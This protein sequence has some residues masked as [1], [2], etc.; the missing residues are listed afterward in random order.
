LAGTVPEAAGDASVK[1]DEAVGG[2]FDAGAAGLAVG[3]ER[4]I[5]S[6]SRRVA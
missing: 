3:Q 6:G 2:G 1:F 5:A 4:L